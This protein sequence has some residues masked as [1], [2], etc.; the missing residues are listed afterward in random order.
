MFKLSTNGNMLSILAS[1]KNERSI[2]AS[3]ESENQRRR[4]KKTSKI[5][6]LPWNSVDAPLVG[7]NNGWQT[8]A[9]HAS[10]QT[11][12]FRFLNRFKMKTRLKGK[13]S[14][15]KRASLSAQTTVLMN[16]S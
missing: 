14:E 6:M 15:P 5:K 7:V 3:V 10:L 11:T 1:V 9:S 13:S 2:S 12:G 8:I 16:W 4:R